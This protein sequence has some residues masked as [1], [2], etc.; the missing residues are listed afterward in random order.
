ML[1]TLR[2]I[3][4]IWR[5]PDLR[6]KVLFTFAMVV[7]YRIGAFIPSPGINFDAVAAIRART[8]LLYTSPS[9]RDS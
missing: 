6:N 2:N 5:I 3:G 4:N 9:P 1:N 8:C 7:F